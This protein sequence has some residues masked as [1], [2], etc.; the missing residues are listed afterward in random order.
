MK[1]V[2]ASFDFVLPSP[3]LNRKVFITEAVKPLPSNTIKKFQNYMAHS[4]TT[5]KKYY[6][7]P[8]IVEGPCFCPCR[9]TL[10]ASL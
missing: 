9:T 2:A 10:K 3:T 8:S 5:S 7:F 1:Q 6:Q 4:E